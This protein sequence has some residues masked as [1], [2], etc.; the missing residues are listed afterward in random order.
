MLR[1]L[2]RACLLLIAVS[3]RAGG[4]EIVHGTVHRDAFWSPALGVRKQ[5]LVYLPAS[6]DTVHTATKR[7]PVAVYLHGR[8]GDETDLIL[9]G[10]LAG[11]MD[12][13]VSRGTS[14]MIVVM[15]DGDDGWW[16]TWESP[17]D[18]A[19]CR[20]EVHRRESSAEFCVATARYDDYIV[21]DVL[22]HVDSTYRTLAR[23]ESRGIAGLSMGGYGAFAIV[24]RHPGVFGAA[25]SHG[26]VLTPGLL[27]DSAAPE[28]GGRTE[29]HVGRTTAELQQATGVRWSSMY[30]MFGV[31]PAT[32]Q[33]RDP[34]RLFAALGSRGVPIPALYADV[35]M[36]DEALQQNRVFRD[37]MQA[38]GIPIR[39]AEWSG[40]HTWIYWRAH[41]P[42]GL[43][44]LA[45][46]LTK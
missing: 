40:T 13:L 6:Y 24:A 14:E 39:Y 32:W 8:W 11:A 42:E 12:S 45:D 17:A 16:T 46:H 29:W 10:R 4:V 21:H 41:V 25:V 7:Y 1:T 15:P 31:D 26:G 36:G 44:F 43:H 5:M 28:S 37:A 23:A 33:T 22:A 30:P 20:T 18:I 3:I 34:A 27:P 35:A 38:H 9:K 2:V 19:T